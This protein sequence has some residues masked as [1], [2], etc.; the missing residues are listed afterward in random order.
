MLLKNFAALLTTAFGSASIT[1]GV[2]MTNGKDSTTNLSKLP[3]ATSTFVSYVS[4]TEY[5]G[6]ASTGS[7]NPTYSFVAGTGDTPPNV[8]DFKLSGELIENLALTVGSITNSISGISYSAVL[9]NNTETSCTIKELAL[10][11]KHY[12]G[13]V[14]LTRDVLQEPVILETGAGKRFEIFIDTQSFVKQQVK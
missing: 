11:I 1:T 4:R 9:K 2:K 5:D 13:C 7:G 12:S 3:N 6:T 10:C 14:F 8:D